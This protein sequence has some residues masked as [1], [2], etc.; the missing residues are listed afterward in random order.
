[1]QPPPGAVYPSAISYSRFTT[2]LLIV[3]DTFRVFRSCKTVFCVLSPM[4][5]LKKNTKVSKF[6][7]QTD[8]HEMVKLLMSK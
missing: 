2:R 7:A 4:V 3:V 5:A 8:K 1:M 6:K